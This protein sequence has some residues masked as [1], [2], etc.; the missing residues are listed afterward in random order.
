MPEAYRLRKSL[1]WHSIV[2]FLLLLPIG[3]G[4]ASSNYLRG[5]ALIGLLYFFFRSVVDVKWSITI[6]LLLFFL[7][8]ATWA[9]DFGSFLPLITLRRMFL[10]ILLLSFVLNYNRFRYKDRLPKSFYFAIGLLIFSYTISTIFSVDF[11]IS[12]FRLFHLI[13][14]QIFFMFIIYRVLH[15]KKMATNGLIALCLASLILCIFGNIEYISNN[16]YFTQVSLSESSLRVYW[17]TYEETQRLGMSGRIHSLSTHPMTFGGF[18]AIV[19]PV[20]IAFILLSRDLHNKLLFFIIAFLCVEG[21]FFSLARSPV[22]ALLGGILIMLIFMFKERWIKKSIFILFIIIICLVGIFSIYEPAQNLILYS[23]KFWEQPI[24]LGGSTLDVRIKMLKNSL[25]YS[26]QRPLF[27][28]GIATGMQMVNYGVFNR[29]LVGALEI[30]WIGRLLETGWIGLLSLLFFLSQVLLM[31][32]KAN[33]F[34][35]NRPE[36]ILAASGIASFVAFLI[37]ATATGEM[38][39]FKLI[40]I[41]FPLLIRAV[42]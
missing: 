7:L 36:N 20:V 4:L 5:I 34:S 11:R 14:E 12:L 32:W 3:L 8:P 42:F 21:I 10:L 35:K 30:F 40:F 13:I 2:V 25:A 23:A 17:S 9:F 16:N 38:S 41:L 28:T 26:M 29:R 1:L 19:F 33:K 31:L 18:L 15:T 22:M 39:T 27:G 37:F 6:Y 24:G